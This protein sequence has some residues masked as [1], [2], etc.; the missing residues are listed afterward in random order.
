MRK[1]KMPAHKRF[2]HECGII[3]EDIQFQYGDQDGNLCEKCFSKVLARLCGSATWPGRSTR[4]TGWSASSPLP[5]IDQPGGGEWVPEKLRSTVVYWMST[6]STKWKTR[7]I[8]AE[9]TNQVC[10]LAP[11]FSDVDKQLRS[12]KQRY[13]KDTSKYWA[14]QIFLPFQIQRHKPWVVYRKIN[15]GWYSCGRRVPCRGTGRG[16]HHARAWNSSLSYTQ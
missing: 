11:T 15:P 13:D 16:T 8:W 9:L 1:T 6:M 7:L 2:C 14:Y 4:R 12:T 5:R 10:V 3:L